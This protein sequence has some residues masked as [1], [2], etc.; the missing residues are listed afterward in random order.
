M[1]APSVEGACSSHSPRSCVGVCGV[2]RVFR[3]LFCA[4][5][6]SR[7]HSLCVSQEC[8]RAF[9]L[10][11]HISSSLARCVRGARGTTSHV[12]RT[13]CTP[14]PTTTHTMRRTAAVA[15]RAGRRGAAADAALASAA[16][17]GDAHARRLAEMQAASNS[18]RSLPS[19]Q[20]VAASLH[21]R[22]RADVPTR[23]PDAAPP[24][25]DWRNELEAAREA[26]LGADPLVD[27]FG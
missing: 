22:T 10:E 7:F 12:A 3:F 16:D 5:R 4:V 9:A 13:L 19:V 21:A 24:P 14:T 27:S 11:T 8:L 2:G 17:D 1:A 6:A 15:L 26:G 18:K 23:P 25:R 20:E